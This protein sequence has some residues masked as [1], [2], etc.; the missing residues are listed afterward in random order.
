MHQMISKTTPVTIIEIDTTSKSLIL[1]GVLLK[2][3]FETTNIPIHAKKISI[4]WLF[5]NPIGIMLK[6]GNSKQ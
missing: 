3:I 5:V 1:N 6:T 4:Q 2:T